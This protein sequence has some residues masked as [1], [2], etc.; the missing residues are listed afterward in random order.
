MMNNLEPHL[1][2]EIHVLRGGAFY[3]GSVVIKQSLFRLHHLLDGIRAYR[4][5]VD[6]YPTVRP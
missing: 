4:R 2:I 3:L 5:P 1:L 6:L